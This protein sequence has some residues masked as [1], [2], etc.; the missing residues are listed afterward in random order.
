MMSLRFL[1][2]S[3]R[4]TTQTALKSAIHLLP[5][6]LTTINHE[7]YIDPEE[8]SIP[9]DNEI[10]SFDPQTSNPVD[11]RFIAQL[12]RQNGSI[13]T[14]F[15][16]NKA[17]SYCAKSA[18]LDLGIQLH[19]IVVKMGFVSNLYTSTAL[20]DMYG[21]CCRIVCS[22]KLFDEMSE[23]NVV[24]WNAL[25]SGYLRVNFPL[26]AIELFA[27]MLKAGIE[28]T[29]FSVSAV[30]VGCSRLE[31]EKIGAQVHSLSLKL[32]FCSSNVVV[33]TGL[34]DMYSKSC[35]LEYSR[36]VFDQMKDKNVITWTSMVTGYARNGNPDEAM[37][38]VR[39]MLGMGLKSNYVTYNSL[40]SSFSNLDYLFRCKQVHSRVIREGFGSNVYIVVTLVTC[41]SK[42]SCSL[43]D[44]KNLCS[45]ILKWDQ[46]SWNAVISGYCNLGCGEQAL[47]CL[48]HM[49]HTGIEIDY[50][51]FT[52]IIGAIGIISGL[53]EARQIHGLIFKSGY[54]S[55]VVIQNGLVSMYARCGVINDAKK[56]FSSMHER[57][58]ISWNSLLSGCAHHGYGTEAVELFEQM[59]RTEIKPNGTTFLCV[60]SACSHS[61]FVNKG[62]EYF[63]LLSNDSSFEPPRMEHYATVVDLFGRG[64]YLNEAESFVASMPIDP[65]PSVYKALLSACEVHG[66][67]EIATRCAK[68]LIDSWPSDPATY[69]LLINVL[70]NGGYWDDAVDVHNL[71]C[72][73]GV[74]KKPGFSWI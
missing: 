40:L 72:D 19:S 35:N 66:N 54:A 42:C 29:S 18:S 65:G 23:R 7:I 36:K 24:T 17:L 8:D 60:L 4:R 5:R 13:C 47:K 39:E 55:D 37:I 45:N 69:V 68:K 10:Y 46:I 52:S 44:F 32:G 16:L 6:A 61:G 50:F 38:L 43:E 26:I 12:Q 74:T 73:R 14:Q 20:V 3:I 67:R 33:E 22:Q 63:D 21:K 57:D 56:I 59:R 27:M 49:R 41:Y 34:I 28:P 71:M 30:I 25:I 9:L 70:R 48:S 64:G 62:L 58:V 1:T 2:A 15:L 31:D 11:S 53:E 51:T